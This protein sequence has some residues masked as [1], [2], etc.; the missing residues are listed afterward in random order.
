MV[1]GTSFHQCAQL[2]D[3]A[4]GIGYFNAMRI[5]RT[6]GHRIQTTAQMDAM[7]DAKE[8]GC[9]IVK[10][11]DAALDGR[12]RESHAMVDG[13]IRE[14]DETFSNG[15]LFPGD[16]NG[17]AEEVIHCRCALLQR[18]RWAL[19]QAELDTLKERA[20]YFG[21]DKTK[22]FEDFKEKYLQAVAETENGGIVEVE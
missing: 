8:K 12:T 5:A 11:W 10:Q 4:S 13:E 18:A 19:D 22:N 15:L 6:E 3:G 7:M 21:L 14:M 20:E 17:S 16:P 9:D 2:L 1:T